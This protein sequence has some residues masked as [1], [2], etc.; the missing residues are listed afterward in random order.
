MKTPRTGSI[1]IPN[2]ISLE[3]HEIEDLIGHLWENIEGLPHHIQELL[4]DSQQPGKVGAVSYALVAGWVLGK[5]EFEF[6][7]SWEGGKSGWVPKEKD[8]N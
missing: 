2:E 1:Q 7:N 5:F 3:D 4:H 6:A 8:V